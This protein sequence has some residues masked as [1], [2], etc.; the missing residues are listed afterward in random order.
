MNGSDA[1]WSIF[2][3][4]GIDIIQSFSTPT[5]SRLDVEG[6]LSNNNTKVQC[7]ATLDV[8]LTLAGS[9]IALFIVQG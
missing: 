1:G 9:Q 2:D 8:P 5:V 3:G 6:R 7:A 4:S